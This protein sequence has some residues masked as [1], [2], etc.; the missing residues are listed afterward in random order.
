MNEAQ[1]KAIQAELAAHY[2]VEE[3]LRLEQELKEMRAK[4]KNLPPEKKKLF[5]GFERQAE[6]L[7]FTIS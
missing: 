5:E 7:G 1:R 3:D 2:K 4:H 6:A